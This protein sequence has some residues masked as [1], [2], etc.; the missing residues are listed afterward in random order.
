[1]RCCG[2]LR[3]LRILGDLR[4]QLAGALEVA[5]AR[6]HQRLQL[7]H[8]QAE[9]PVGGGERLELGH[10]LLGLGRIHALEGGDD[11]GEVGQFGR[12]Q[13]G[14]QRHQGGDLGVQR[15][16]QLRSDHGRQRTIGLGRARR[17][18]VEFGPRR[19]RVLGDLGQRR[20][21]G[22]TGR[23]ALR[24][25]VLAPAD[26]S[27]HDHDEDHRGAHDQRTPAAPPFLELVLAD[28]LVDLMKSG[29]I[30]QG[31]L[32]DYRGIST[33]SA[34][35]H[36][37]PPELWQTT[38]QG[39]LGALYRHRRFCN[40]SPRRHDSH[41]GRMTNLYRFADQRARRRI[42]SFDRRE[43]S[44][45]L[46]LYSLRVASGEWRD[47]AIDFRPGMAIFSIFRHTAEQPLFAIAKVPGARPGRLHGLQRPAQ[48]G[49][50]RIARRRAQRLRPQAPASAELSYF[51]SAVAAPMPAPTAAPDQRR[52]QQRPARQRADGKAR[53][54]ADAA[55]GHGA[56]APSVAAG[57]KRQGK[58]KQDQGNRL[59]FHGTTS[60]GVAAG[61]CRPNYCSQPLKALMTGR[62]WI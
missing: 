12:R 32:P 29:G 59:G 24:G 6:R 9:R 16:A 1:M 15:L 18:L 26:Q 45:L 57:G 33:A 41:H 8:A 30:G 54:G 61:L 35:V 3:Q 60:K 37:P 11:V 42:V 17:L 51:L 28:G 21:I 40:N 10:H 53:A 46:N 50:R 19:R 7:T 22:G 48:A 4:P 47:Y 38:E 49:A 56:F 52:R 23:G 34:A 31:W 62:S 36:S 5:L 13:G 55:A 43:L 14:R 58:G 44:R 39:I 20:R 2:A 25:V 27:R